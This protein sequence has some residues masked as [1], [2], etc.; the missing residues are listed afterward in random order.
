[1]T[2]IESF[3]SSPLQNI[4]ECLAIGPEKLILVGSKAQLD[5]GTQHYRDILKSHNLKTVLIPKPIES[6]SLDDV[7]KEFELLIRQNCPCAI[8]LF[9]GNELHLV[10]AGAAFYALKDRFDVVLQKLDM[11]RGV[12]LRIDGDKTTALDKRPKLTVAQSVEIYG[13]SVC[14]DGNETV[15]KY[16]SQDINAL[17]DIA[18]QDPSSW[19]RKL[20]ALNF[21]EG[22]NGCHSEDLNVAVDVYCNCSGVADPE[23]SREFFRQ[24]IEQLKKSRVITVQEDRGGYYRYRY[25][26]SLVRA[27]LKK[28]GNVLEYKTF[29]AARECRVEGKPLFNDCTIGVMLDWNGDVAGDTRNE[30][31]IMVMHG[32]VPVFISCKNGVIDDEELYKLNSVALKLGGEFVKKALIAT[33]FEPPKEKTKQA[34]LQRAKDMGVVFEPDAAQLSPEGWN[35]LFQKILK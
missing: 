30:I 19:N 29:F 21:F 8:D 11:Q 24:I 18:R 31:D 28:E 3:D 34:V 27:A 16:D 26:N 32:A 12:I 33:D 10:A 20:H 15:E 13:G 9:G 4:A 35:Q 22:R 7:R 1:M 25:K 5:A 23:E 2:L 14:F 17:W 6:Q